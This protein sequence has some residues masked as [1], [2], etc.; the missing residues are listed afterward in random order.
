[1]YCTMAS[2]ISSPAMRTDFEYTMPDSEMTATS[3][4]PPPMSTIMLPPGSCVGRPAPIAGAQGVWN[5]EDLARGRLHGRIT[6]R[7]LLD[8]GDARGHADDDARVHERAP[9]VHLADEVVEHLLR[10]V[11]VGDDTVL[12]RPDGLDVP[13]RAPHHRLG[14]VPDGE[15]R[16]IGL[17][18]GDDRGLV[19]HDALAADVHE[20]GGRGEV[21]CEVVGKESGEDAQQHVGALP[22]DCDT[23]G[24]IATTL[25]VY[26]QRASAYKIPCVSKR[27]ASIALA[28]SGSFGPPGQPSNLFAYLS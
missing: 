19:H 21:D 9:P 25:R 3:V 7:A 6:N 14:L 27:M 22:S 17:V 4:V 12:E 11:E 16:M 24:R 20:G 5:Q 2:S 13:W 26:H 18:D 15:H 10:H 28:G 8:L 1:M 23:L